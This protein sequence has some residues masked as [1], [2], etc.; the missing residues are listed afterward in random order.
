MGEGSSFSLFVLVIGI[1]GLLIGASNLRFGACDRTAA[2]SVQSVV[3][4]PGAWQ[5]ALTI[6]SVVH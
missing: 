4:H 5:A 6:R 1:S 2:R 3:Y